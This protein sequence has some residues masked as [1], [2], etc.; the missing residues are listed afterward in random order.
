MAVDFGLEICLE[1]SYELNQSFP[2]GKRKL[3]NDYDSPGFIIEN[4]I[5]F[6]NHIEMDKIRGNLYII[7]L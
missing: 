1:K 3:K 2:R 6:N 4:T 7:Y 5:N